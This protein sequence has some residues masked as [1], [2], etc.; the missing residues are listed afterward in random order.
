VCAEPLRALP[1]TLRCE[2]GHAFDVAREGYVDLLPDGYGRSRRHG[3]TAEMVR[4]RAR[5]LGRGHHDLLARAVLETGRGVIGEARRPADV[6]GRGTDGSGHT[7]GSAPGAEA[8]RP[9]TVIL[10]A[11]CATGYYIGAFAREPWI[12]PDAVAPGP[13]PA[14]PHIHLLGADL[15][16]HAVRIAARQN[17]GVLFVVND[18]THRLC[19]PDAS[20]D[21]LLDIFAPRNAR[22]FARVVRPGGSL[23]VVVPTPDHH[24]ELRA[25]LPLL[26]IAP[27]KEERVTDTL[28]DAF[29][30]LSRDV[31]Q[32]TVTLSPD[33]ITDLVAMTPSAWHV[34]ADALARAGVIGAVE[35]TLGFI[36]LRFTRVTQV[37]RVTRM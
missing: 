3:D 16:K 23:L 35:T 36:L 2:R 12:A 29:R 18:S 6:P 11:G 13:E 5:F 10:E 37:T 34:D 7:P 27:D 1:G 20:V 33:D 24:R 22:E 30:L 4:A 17:P 32:Y 26:G 15:S 9:A 31:L 14:A 19:V 25:R 21:L 28:G 8:A